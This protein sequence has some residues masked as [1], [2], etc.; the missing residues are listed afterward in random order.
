M[1][2]VSVIIPVYGVERYIARC[3]K[4]LFEQTLDDIE[5]IFIDD[6]S[7]D[8]SIQVLKEVIKDYP[9]RHSQI[10]IERMPHNC[11][12]PQVRKVGVG[13]ATGD[14]IIACDSDDYIDRNMYMVMYEYAVNND[15][16]LVQCDLDVVD[17]TH[18]LHTFSAS[19]DDVTSD[20]LRGL[21]IDG[22]ISNSL[23]NKLVKRDI[24][25]NKELA[26][27]TVGM[28]ED[29]ALAIQLAFFSQRLGYVKKPFYKAYQNPESM[30]RVPGNEQINKR[31]KESLQNSRMVIDFLTRHGYEDNSKAI[32]RAKLRPKMVL[33][34]V[35]SKVEYINLWKE[36]YSEINSVV[37][38]DKRLP[39]S[40]RIK[41]LLIQLYCYPLF[42][43]IKKTF[44]K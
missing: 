18:V 8:K 26:F 42:I 39:R 7:P 33:T 1:P 23:C 4:S 10:R 2:K 36:T 24:Y 28:D 19:K 31:Y 11:G 15:C 16:D 38:F 20:I 12:L 25:C 13:L 9:H 32:I 17:D 37:V 41:S 21:I 29:N 44:K 40:I 5:Y 22:E 35:I 6:C 3:S 30:S 43:R 34:P 14:Y 27:P